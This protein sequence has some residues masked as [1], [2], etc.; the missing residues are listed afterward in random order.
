M[1]DMQERIATAEE[2]LRRLK[3]R[4]QQAEAK[5]KRNEVQQA[6]KDDLRRKLIVGSVVLQ[7]VQ[8]GELPDAQF[9][10][11]LEAALTRPEDRALFNLQ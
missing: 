2:R 8:S 7:R 10:K 6:R 9:R 4:H 3:E 11:W 1:K 5:R